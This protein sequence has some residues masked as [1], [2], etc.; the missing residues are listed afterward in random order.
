MLLKR[1]HY[2]LVP[3]LIMLIT[4]CGVTSE[5]KT[6]SAMSEEE[7]QEVI[8]EYVADSN[9]PEAELEDLV[10]TYYPSVDLE[11]E[12]EVVEEIVPE[13]FLEGVDGAI[14]SVNGL[15]IEARDVRD[16]YVYLVTFMEDPILMGQVRGRYELYDFLETDHEILERFA[17]DEWINSMAAASQFP[18][19]MNRAIIGML[20]GIRLQVEEGANFVNMVVE[21]SMEPGADQGGG[22]LGV[23]TQGDLLPIFELHVFNDEPGEVSEPFPTIF[24]WHLSQVIDRDDSLFPRTTHARH[25]LIAHGMDPEYLEDAQQNAARYRNMAEIE[26]LRDDLN[27]LFPELA[28]MQGIEGRDA[29]Q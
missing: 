13:P 14:I 1:N 27:D 16:L 15:E 8:P 28:A 18:P 20:D 5:Y 7:L 9:L 6:R 12:D 2:I 22:D 19:E 10:D 24:G 23:T 26:L 25:L 4:G 29:P 17:A 21:N 11:F 3:V